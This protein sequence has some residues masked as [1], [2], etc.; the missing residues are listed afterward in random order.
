MAINQKRS[1]AEDDANQ[2][3]VVIQR[4]LS[5]KATNKRPQVGQPRSVLFDI[6]NG[7]PVNRKRKG[8]AL[9]QPVDL[10]IL[11]WLCFY[12]RSSFHV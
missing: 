8:Y 6:Q 7:C 2:R 3:A 11:K 10:S 12:R 9:A 4:P 1:D 5:K